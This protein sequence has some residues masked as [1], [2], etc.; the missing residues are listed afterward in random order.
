MRERRQSI[1]CGFTILELMIVVSIITTLS[2]IS[3]PAFLQV[4]S[5][6]FTTSCINNLRQIS[7][8][9]DQYALDHHGRIP[10]LTDLTPLYLK[11]A[12]VCRGGGQYSVGAQDVVTCTQ[13]A[14]GHT[15]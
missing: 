2:A 15:Y 5:K 14:S 12:P 3:V 6:S 1:R 11:T 13:S 4:R 9:C 10:A 8:A 7:G